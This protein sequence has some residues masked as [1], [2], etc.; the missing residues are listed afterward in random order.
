MLPPRALAE[1]SRF[2]TEFW[3]CSSRPCSFFRVF[4][5]CSIPAAILITNCLR[6]CQLPV[7]R[8]CPHLLRFACIWNSRVRLLFQ[9]RGTR[10][11]ARRS[12]SL[13]KRYSA[14]GA[15]HLASF[16][17]VQTRANRHCGRRVNCRRIELNVL[18]NYLFVD[19]KRCPARKF[20]FLVPNGIMFQNS[21]FAHH[22]SVHVAQ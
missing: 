22:R 9:L 17:F 10:R 7:P 3:S 6:T 2:A 4:L 1:F 14:K 20:V 19:H 16:F 15:S 21:V 18:D 11:R 12:A 5:A 13:T 8:T